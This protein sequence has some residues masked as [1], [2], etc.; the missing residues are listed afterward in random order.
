MTLL[1]S[2]A[3]TPFTVRLLGPSAYGLLTIITI[4]ASYASI[5]DLGMGPASTKFGATAMAE[6]DAVAEAE[7]VWTAAVMSAIPALAVAMGIGIGAPTIAEDVLRLPGPLLST[8]TL[9]L[10]IVTITF[11]ARVIAN[12]INTPQ[13]VR[14]RWSSYTVIN[15][16]GSVVQVA[17]VPVVIALGGGVVGAVLVG[18][19]AAVS[20]ALA[21]L[22]VSSRLLPALWPPR[23]RP[24]LVPPLAR[25]GGSLVVASLAWIPLTNAERFFLARTGSLAELAHYSV[26]ATAAALLAVIPLAVAQPLLPAF[27]RQIALNHVTEWAVLYRRV[28]RLV[29]V[30]VVPSALVLAVV[31]R[32]FFSVWAGREYGI[33]S[34]VPF[35]I[36]VAGI[37]VNATAYAPSTL[38]VSTGR[39][40][41]LARC[42]LAE[43]PLFLVAAAVMTS[44]W[45]AEGAALAFMLRVVGDAVALT[46]LARRVAP[47]RLPLMPLDARPYGLA[48]LPLAPVPVSLAVIPRASWL[49]M[50][51]LALL[52]PAHCAILWRR[53]LEAE[54]RT[55]TCALRDRVLRRRA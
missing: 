30:T 16:A 33:S 14:L 26:A 48:L 6:G 25:F 42:Y 52:L 43:V 2:L 3:A 1:V 38:L 5:A 19:A 34:T 18:A 29:M 54:E 22:A 53:V 17:T 11:V 40:N 55:F 44:A 46:I 10:R 49:H 37:V 32:P 20:I 15:T 39:A 23:L 35:Y 41:L 13:L 50:C 36:L 12:V 24:S 21:H 7:V 8:G 27:T 45:G 9:G 28:T 31:A 51:L 4:V 47:A